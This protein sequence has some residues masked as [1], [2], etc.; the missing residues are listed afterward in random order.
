MLESLFQSHAIWVW[1]LAAFL[2]GLALNLTPCVYPMVPVTVAFFSGQ[3]QGRTGYVVWLGIAYVAG[4]SLMYALLGTLAAQTGALFGSWLQH[5]AV[6]M[7]VAALIIALAL[8]MFGLYELQPPRWLAQRFGR[9]TVGPLGALVMG[10]TVGLIAAP[11]I[12]PFLLSLL[13]VVSQVGNPVLG[14]GL[15]LTTGIGM[16]VPYII[17]GVMAH[18]VTQLPKAGKWLVWSKRA[19]G[20]VL[21]AFS[22]YLLGIAARQRSATAGRTAA[23]AVAWQP[24]SYARLQQARQSG[25]PVLVDIYADWCLPCVE[26]DHVTFRHPDVA[27]RLSSVV[28]LRVD[29]TGSISRE[30]EQLFEDYNVYGVPTLLLFDAQGRERPDLRIQGFL[31]PKRFLER[32]DQLNDNAEFGMRNSE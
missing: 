4:I 10:L 17:L 1:F 20:V 27:Q 5:P 28:T 14:F 2:S 23:S 6:L 12:G 8:S 7:L 21:I 32:L 31:P 19:L 26:M 15:L 3:G 16:G 30:A 9:A 18:R 13:L 11:C 29:A 25:Q 24:Y 22:V